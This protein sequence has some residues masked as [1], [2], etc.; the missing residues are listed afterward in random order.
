[1]T[2]TQQHTMYLTYP[3]YQSSL[4][5][6]KKHDLWLFPGG[7]AL[8]GRSRNGKGAKE[9]LFVLVPMTALASS[10]AACKSHGDMVTV[11][12]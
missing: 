5:R 3:R 7:V 2:T 9:V 1:M 8:L 10:E 12:P 11:A 6:M 4:G